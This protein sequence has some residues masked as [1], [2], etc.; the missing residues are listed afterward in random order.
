M[1]QETNSTYNDSLTINETTDHEFEPPRLP[2]LVIFF[3]AIYALECFIGFL[4]N[5]VAIWILVKMLRTSKTPTNLCMLNLSIADW[6]YCVFVVPIIADT[7]CGS[8]LSPWQRLGILA[9]PLCKMFLMYQTLMVF[10]SIYTIVA[11]TIDRYL[12][13]VRPI[14]SINYRNA[15]NCVR[16]LGVVWLV[17]ALVS[18]PHFFTGYI[19]SDSLM[20]T[21]AIK[22]SSYDRILSTLL[23]PN[24][25][26]KMWAVVTFLFT[27]VVPLSMVVGLYHKI[28]TTLKEREQK[29]HS[30]TITAANN[31]SYNNNN[32]NNDNIATK[33]KS[34]VAKNPSPACLMIKNTNAT[35]STDR[36]NDG[37]TYNQNGAAYLSVE[38]DL[39]LSTSCAGTDPGCVVRQKNGASAGMSQQ[40][41]AARKRN[42]RTAK[43]VM[44]VVS[45]FAVCLLPFQIQFQLWAFLDTEALYEASPLGCEVSLRLVYA[46]F[47]L[48]SIVNPFVY[49]F[50]CQPFKEAMRASAPQLLLK[51]MDNLG[52]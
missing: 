9:K 41:V 40:A 8:P 5:S 2:G 36:K 49:T 13:V 51:A 17:A 1:E 32:N 23:P 24:S 12:A 43:L 48:N 11:M 50:Q 18:L 25:A 3:T 6:V 26:M 47:F 34:P 45:V 14:E 20:N 19:Y 10:V 21:C 15:R 52:K 35:S 7:L 16:V 30:A 39:E 27:Y 22:W 46:F 31:S 4:G 33:K 38:T 29:K 44:I 37:P 28:L 42:E